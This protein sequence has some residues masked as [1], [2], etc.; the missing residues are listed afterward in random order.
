M[1]KKLT[2][3]ELT[4]LTGYDF[5]ENANRRQYHNG[6]EYHIVNGSLFV[7]KNGCWDVVSEIIW[8]DDYKF[9]HK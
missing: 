6:K 9:E 7:G 1:S 3:T 8:T 5:S 4:E 2:D